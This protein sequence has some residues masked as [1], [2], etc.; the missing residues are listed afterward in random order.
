MVHTP[1]VREAAADLYTWDDFV[2]LD[3]GDSRELIDGKLVE[4]EVPNGRHERV[5]AEII[6]ALVPWAREHGGGLVLASGY[7]VRISERRGVMPDVQYFRPGN[8]PLPRQDDGLVDGRP[9]LVVEVVS[10]SSCRYDRIVKA[11][12]YASIG[13]PEYWIV[14]PEERTIERLLLDAGRWVIATSAANDE[15]FE[16]PGFE[17][18]RLDLTTAWGGFTSP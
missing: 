7:K 2:A 1:P 5:V 6:A 12:F 14:D 13:V 10:P 15:P 3:E 17:G 18:L 4:V 16:P 8:N 9:D 11:R